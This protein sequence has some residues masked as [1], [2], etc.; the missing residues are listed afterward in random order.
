MSNYV[1]NREKFV[2]AFNFVVAILAMHS[3]VKWLRGDAILREKAGPG[4]AEK[5]EQLES[6][7]HG[8]AGLDGA[9][10]TT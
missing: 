8:M 2:T 7:L 1:G 4:L 6:A 9:G 3:L 5:L 10:E